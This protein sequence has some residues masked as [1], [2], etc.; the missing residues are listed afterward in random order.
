MDSKTEKGPRTIELRNNV[1]VDNTITQDVSIEADWTPEEERHIRRKVDL[2]IIPVLAL[3]FFA[4]Q[5][6]R[7]NISAAMTSTLMDDLGVNTNAINVGSQL[8]SAG[9][10]LTEIPS[11]I[12]LQRFGP[13]KWLSFQIFAWGLVAT[14][15]AFVQNYAE[16]L[17]TRL[18]LGLLEGG[19]IPGALYYLSTWYKK[20][21]TS[22]RVTLFFFGQMFSAATSSLISA[23]IL[24][25]GSKHGLEGW[26]WIFLVEG[27]IT[28]AIGLVFVLILPPKVGDGRVLLSLGRWSYFSPRE[29]HIIRTRVLLET[30]EANTADRVRITARDVWDTVKQPKIIQHFFLTLVSMSALSGLTSYTPLLIKSFGYTSVQANAMAS[31]PIY[32]SMVFTYTLARIGDR[33]NHR[34]PL[35]LLA[36]TWNVI[37]YICLRNVPLDSSKNHKYGVLIAANIG[38]AA[39]HIQNVGWLAINC[40]KPQERSVAMA[41]IIMAA[42]MSG[43][44]G[45]QIF[46]TA[47][48]PH[49]LKGLTAICALAAA[50]WVQAV[51]LNIYYYVMPSDMSR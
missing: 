7:G 9:I 39:M 15:Q 45:H 24:T 38:Y 6:D 23:G 17:A 47:D 5:M 50:S 48:A 3:A 12:L 13:K 37:A 42:N 32:C 49:Y 18:L 46:R 22:S 10:V 31:V 1:D 25:M 30:P 19:Y 16:F 4:L 8:M 36:I 44:A 34:G 14:F 28:L 43:I 29:S 41:V 2:I 21:E 26:R 35:V 40:T 33:T 20:S 11:N 27:I 51:I